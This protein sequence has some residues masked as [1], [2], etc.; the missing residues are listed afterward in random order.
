MNEITTS[1]EIIEHGI[2]YSDYFQGTSGVMLPLY[3]NPKT[4]KKEVLNMLKEEINILWDHIE[5]TAS[6]NNFQGDLK[7][8][9][10][11]KLD[12]IQEYIKKNGNDITC[13]DMEYQENED[14]ENPVFIFSIEFNQKIKRN[15]NVYS[16]EQIHKKEKLKMK[17]YYLKDTKENIY[18]A[19]SVG[20]VVRKYN[21]IVLQTK[22]T[23][24]NLK[25]N[26]ILL[27]PKPTPNKLIELLI[28]KGKGGKPVEFTD[29]SPE[30]FE[31]LEILEDGIYTDSTGFEYDFG[32]NVFWD[33]SKKVAVLI[34]K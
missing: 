15:R 7:K 28:N 3:I 17:T 27:L 31:A 34:L 13:P 8:G 4:T 26:G 33:S 16:K 25:Y 10:N 9:I 29:R 19:I 1:I 5:Y 22:Y 2:M 14:I 12:E 32:S 6:S 11:S 18:N 23:A 20:Y 24:E 30:T 21:N